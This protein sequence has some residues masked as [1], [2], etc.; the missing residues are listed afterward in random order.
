[1]AVLYYL[2]IL[3]NGQGFV[4]P[5]QNPWSIESFPRILLDYS[6]KLLLTIPIWYIVFKLLPPKPVWKRIVVH[7]LALPVFVLGWK[8]L[9]YWTCE[10]IGYGHLKGYGQVWDLYIPVLFYVLQFALFHVWDYSQ[11]L[12]EQQ[13][14]AAELTQLAHNAELYNLKAQLQPHFL[15]N[16]LNSINASLPAREEHTRE[17]ITRL[18]DTLRFAMNAAQHDFI[19]F[20]QELAFVKDYLALEQERFADR[21]A[22]HYTIDD[23]AMNVPVPPFILQ[24]LVEN[25]LKHGIAKKL[26]GGTVTISA[27]MQA[28]TLILN[29][30]DTGV[31]INGYAQPQ[32]LQK[33]IG[34]RNTHLRL[35]KLF[36][37]GIHI[38]AAQPQ[39]TSVQFSIPVTA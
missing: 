31:G 7:L 18:A 36:G 11:R 13:Q 24:P 23:A 8:T 27:Q 5:G 25:A 10:Q 16:T 26:E 1:M 39:G 20:R 37:Q 19:P 15:F 2:T 22:V 9:Y 21:L 12:Q 33:G 30:T 4:K 35:Q 32:L 6:L 28:G 14:K 38:Q 3:Y 29:V 17:L 34:L